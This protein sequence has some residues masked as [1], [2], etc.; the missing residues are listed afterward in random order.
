VE[1]KVLHRFLPFL[2]W[3][4]KTNKKSLKK[5]LIAGL[6]GAVVVLPQGMAFA[7]I[8]GM[9]PIYGLYTAMIMPIVAAL[10]GS[11]KHMITGP[12]T[13]ISIVVFSAVTSHGLLPGTPD[14]IAMVLVITFVA[15]LIQFAMGIARLGTL[16]NFISHTVVIGFTAGAAILI[17][18]KQLPYALGV[19]LPNGLKIYEIF[20][21]IAHKAADI[22]YQVALIAI[23]TFIVAF[24]GR[25]LAPKLPFMLIAMLVGSLLAYFL[26]GEEAGI[27]LVGEMPANLPPF[28]VP[29][30]SLD[31]ITKIAPDAFAIALLGLIEAVAIARSIAMQS[32]QRIDG[33][34]EF[35]G[36]GLSNII[37]SF[38]SSFAGSGS[39]TRSGVNYE[40]GAKTPLAAIFAALLLVLI[41]LF[42]APLT[43]FL[44]IAT[45]AGIIFYVSYNLIDVKHIKEILKVSGRETTVLLITFLSTLFLRLEFAI[46][47]GVIFSLIFYLQR[48]STPRVVPLGILE[49]D[50]E[51]QIVSSL[52]KKRTKKVPGV[53]MV[54]IDGSIFFGSVIHIKNKLDKMVAGHNTLLIIGNSINLVDMAGA[55]MLVHLADQLRKQGGGLYVSGLK[56]RTRAYLLRGSFW[57]HIGLENIHEDE[58]QALDYILNS[59]SA[60]ADEA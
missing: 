14:F 48:T 57:K 18:V 40:A 19:Y 8:A 1:K 20:A 44:P 58:Y 11:S 38:F 34:Q 17:A 45:M 47:I 33:N 10:F 24:V 15:G 5:D 56:R 29:N 23:V 6:T 60:A 9:P 26:G 4:P 3:L 39:F 50:G 55:E 43:A 37:G 53:V 49:K 42:V 22:N 12:A 13:A 52:R 36:Q 27:A 41:V 28:S 54:R 46:Y 16:V 32:G 31:L 7:I 25:K 2:E 59:N 21:A 30:L 35:I 51:K